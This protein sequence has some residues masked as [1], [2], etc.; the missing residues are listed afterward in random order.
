MKSRE[1]R[2][3]G[4]PSAGLLP[5]KTSRGGSQSECFFSKTQSHRSKSGFADFTLRT[6]KAGVEGE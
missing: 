6:Q 3:T 5:K 1:N 2:R 4:F